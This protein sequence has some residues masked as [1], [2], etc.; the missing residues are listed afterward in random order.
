MQHLEG[1]GAWVRDACASVRLDQLEP[2]TRLDC[3]HELSERSFEV[4]VLKTRQDEALMN[5]VERGLPC[6]RQRLEEILCA[7]VDVRGSDVGCE[8]EFWTAIRRRS[9]C[10]RTTHPS[11]HSAH[12]QLDWTYAMSKPTSWALFGTSALTSLSQIPVRPASSALFQP[13]TFRHPRRK[14]LPSAVAESK[15][16]RFS[17]VRSIGALIKPP[18]LPLTHLCW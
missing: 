18:E 1:L 10:Q 14:L 5:K 7:Q 12:Q 6:R 3:T 17:L 4:R 9:S 11:T 13:R 16:L 15:I 2:S 8:E